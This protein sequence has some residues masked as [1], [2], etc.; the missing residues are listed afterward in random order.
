IGEEGITQP[1]REITIENN[2]FRNDGRYTTA[3]VTN[4]TATEAKL[5]GNKISGSVVPL[6]GDG[7]VQ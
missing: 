4:M 7:D 1:T 3:F 5:K 2:T 6:K